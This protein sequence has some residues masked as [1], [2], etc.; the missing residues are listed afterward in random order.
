MLILG[1]GTS[2]IHS[3]KTLTILEFFKVY[4]QNGN[5]WLFQSSLLIFLINTNACTAIVFGSE[6]I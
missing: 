6:I 4:D 2:N 3:E 5:F 1:F